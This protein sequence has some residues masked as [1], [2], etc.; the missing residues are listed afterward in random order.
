MHLNH[1]RPLCPFFCEVV[2]IRKMY[3]LPVIGHI[4]CLWVQGSIRTG[5]ASSQGLKLSLRG[6]QQML[7]ILARV[8][9]PGGK[10]KREAYFVIWLVAPCVDLVGYLGILKCTFTWV[11]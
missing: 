1:I 11:Q 8:P 9:L 5:K 3:Q 10:G 2:G 4:P 6:S 7:Q